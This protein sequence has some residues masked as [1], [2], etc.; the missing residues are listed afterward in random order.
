M[1]EKPAAMKRKA[2]FGETVAPRPAKIVRVKN[3]PTHATGP[4]MLEVEVIHGT[5]KEKVD[6][7]Q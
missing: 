4:Q 7:K 3:S 5:Q 2:L 6:F 1:Q